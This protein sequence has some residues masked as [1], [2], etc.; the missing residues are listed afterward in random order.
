[1]AVSVDHVLELDTLYAQCV[2]VEVSLSQDR[3]DPAAAPHFRL[4]STVQA[5]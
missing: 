1:M 2:Y 3:L 4:C 5:R